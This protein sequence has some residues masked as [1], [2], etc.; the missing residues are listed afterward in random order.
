MPSWTTAWYLCWLLASV[1]VGIT[2][3]SGEWGGCAAMVMLAL[4]A[5]LM[6]AIEIVFEA[7]NKSREIARSVE[8]K[9]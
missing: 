4:R 2:M 5:C 6:S 8:D 7:L 3:K 9:P 1:M